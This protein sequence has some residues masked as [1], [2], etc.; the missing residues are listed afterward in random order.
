MGSAKCENWGEKERNFW[1]A[2][3][4]FVWCIGTIIT[5][6][7][8][9]SPFRAKDWVDEMDTLFP[10]KMLYNSPFQ[11]CGL[12]AL[13]IC[14]LQG[15]T[16]SFNIQ[17]GNRENIFYSNWLST[18]MTAMLLFL[19]QRVSRTDFVKDFLWSGTVVSSKMDFFW[20]YEYKKLWIESTLNAWTWHSCTSPP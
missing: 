7:K 13:H 9:V 12:L 5:K 6:I 14:I 19:E 3:R 17:P 10:F 20:T 4:G 11:I 16:H 18:F 2:Y 8:K 1:K 15:Q